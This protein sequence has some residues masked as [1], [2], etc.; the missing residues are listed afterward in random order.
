[1]LII[2]VFSDIFTI[3]LPFFTIDRVNMYLSYKALGPTKP[4]SLTAS[5]GQAS[6]S[7]VTPNRWRWSH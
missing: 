1:M 7:G 3:I 5:L 6:F 4:I 2:V